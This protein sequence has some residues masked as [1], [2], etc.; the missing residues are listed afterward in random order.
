MMSIVVIIIGLFALLAILG[1]VVT[2]VV[3]FSNQKKISD[4]VS[5]CPDCGNVLSNNSKVC[6]K[7]GKER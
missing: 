2:I 4:N 6:S 3:I 7:C 1:I 5:Y